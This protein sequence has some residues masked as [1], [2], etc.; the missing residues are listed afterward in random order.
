[1]ADAGKHADE[2]WGKR[3]LNIEGYYTTF[4]QRV[5]PD[6]EFGNEDRN[7][8]AKWLK[9]QEIKGADVHSSQGYSALHVSGTALNQYQL[10]QIPEWRKARWNFFRR[11]IRRPM[12]MIEAG[13]IKTTGAPWTAIRT[14]RNTFS[15]GWKAMALFYMFSYHMIYRSDNWET[16]MNWKI[17]NQKPR[18]LP[19]DHGVLASQDQF[20]RE[21]DDYF[22]QNFKKSELYAANVQATQKGHV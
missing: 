15:Y 19:D 2:A 22:N 20:K 6:G 1:M 5:S 17:Y 18:S 16:K 10:E 7:W 13:I 4:V 11:T 8:R 3:Q 14:C 12:D 21:K 9:D